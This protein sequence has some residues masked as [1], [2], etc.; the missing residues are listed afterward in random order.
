MTLD[1]RINFEK[2]N[3]LES[4]SGVAKQQKYSLESGASSY[5]GIDFSSSATKIATDYLSKYGYQAELYNED[6]LEFLKKVNSQ[7]QEIIKGEN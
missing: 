2:R 5:V 4:A 7:P 1:R 3:V 6:A